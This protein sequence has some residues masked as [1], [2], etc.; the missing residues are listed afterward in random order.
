[1]FFFR[2]IITAIFRFVGFFTVDTEADATYLG[3]NPQIYTLVEPNAYFISSC[4]P[5]MRPLARRVFNE[6]G[7]AIII[8]K[9]YRRLTSGSNTTQYDGSGVSLDVP[10]GS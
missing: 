7:L 2:G 8:Y 1:M 6:S 9:R 10:R 4:L 3:V 5:G